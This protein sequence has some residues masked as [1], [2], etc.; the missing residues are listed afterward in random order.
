M[1]RCPQ[2]NSTYND[3]L[4]NY[5]LED[6]TPLIAV[7]DTTEPA[8]TSTVAGIPSE[9]TVVVVRPTL[10]KKSRAWIWVLS[11][12]LILGV[13]GASLIAFVAYRIES[14]RSR[15]N[16]A[17]PASSATPKPTLSPKPTHSPTPSVSPTPDGSSTPEPVDPDEV[18]PIAWNTAAVSF[19][20]DVGRKY[21]FECPP[22]GTAQS[23][24]GSDI[25]TADSSICTAAVH[26]GIINLEDGGQVEVEFRPG[27]SI[28]GSTTR[29]GITSSTYGEYPH[30]IIVR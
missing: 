21:K 25:Y 24:W 28:Y 2:C 26:A 29:N 19:N 11:I 10:K 22:N 1:K 18:T 16:I 20:T 7:N 8:I 14:E 9:P 30:S 15:V 12:L 5:C 4:L 6:G 13:A 17:I 27:R 23:V 3:T